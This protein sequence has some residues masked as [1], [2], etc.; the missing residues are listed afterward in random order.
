MCNWTFLHLFVGEDDVSRVDPHFT[1]KLTAV[2]FA[3]PAPP[4]FASHPVDVQSLAMIELPVG[5]QGGWH[6]SPRK[7]W[8]ICLAGEMGYE[9]GDGTVFTL[10][11]GNCILTTDTRG[12]GHNSWNAGT[13]PVRLA[14]VQL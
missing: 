5:W 3:P 8:V 12:R 7:Q 10:Q 11:P 1:Q 9:A 14:L 13:V 4:M 6:P 2:N